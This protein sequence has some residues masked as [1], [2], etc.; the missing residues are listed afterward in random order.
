ML[1]FVLLDSFYHEKVVRQMGLMRPMKPMWLTEQIWP[2]RPTKPVWP[3]QP[4]MLSSPMWPT[5]LIWPTRISCCLMMQIWSRPARPMW[6]MRSF[7]HSPPSQNILQLSQKWEDILE[8]RL[9]WTSCVTSKWRI[10]I[11]LTINLQP[12]GSPSECNMTISFSWIDIVL[13]ALNALWINATISWSL[14]L[15]WV[16]MRN[17]GSSWM[18]CSK[19]HLARVA[20]AIVIAELSWT[21]SSKR[22][23]PFN[24]VIIA[25]MWV[26]LVVKVAETFGI[27]GM[28][29]C[30]EISIAGLSFGTGRCFAGL[31]FVWPLKSSLL[32][33]A[34][35]NQFVEEGLSPKN[36]VYSKDLFNLLPKGKALFELVL[37]ADACTSI[38]AFAELFVR[39][40]GSNANDANPKAWHETF[41]VE[42]PGTF[43]ERGWTNVDDNPYWN[44]Q[45]VELGTRADAENRR[46]WLILVYWNA[47]NACWEKASTAGELRIISFSYC[48]GCLGS[49]PGSNFLPWHSP[50]VSFVC[51]T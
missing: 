43:T 28:Q 48:T 7:S 23:C 12:S 9:V 5:Q 8:L 1:I 27:I 26:N 30:K 25:K 4:M 19:R 40:T 11:K 39:V 17:E 6:P 20:I 37:T 41:I 38:A 29:S 33:D 32:T 24:A 36:E 50:R 35:T 21:Q 47:C 51:V 34:T 42:D 22:F 15:V 14:S 10:G 45:I 2:T 3:T 46:L 49:N 44:K 13:R 16:A 18:Q 31:S